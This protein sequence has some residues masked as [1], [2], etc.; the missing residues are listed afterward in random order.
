MDPL[1]VIASIAGVSTAGISLA[2][3]IYDAI[4]SMRDAPKEASSI[5]RGLSDLSSTLRELRR[6]LNDGR[7]IYRRRL[8]RRVASAV[9]R[10]SQIQHEIENLLVLDGPGS[11]GRLKWIFRKS[12]TMALLYAIESHKTGI[13]LVLHTMMLAVQLKQ[14]SN[15]NKAPRM[16]NVKDD[17]NDDSKDVTLARQQAETTVQ[18]SFHLLQEFAA[19]NVPPD[20]QNSHHM[21]NDGE[22]G[23]NTSSRQLQVWPKAAHDDAT[24]LYDLVFSAAVDAE[25]DSTE[26]I[27]GKTSESDDEVGVTEQ[28]SSLVSTQGSSTSQAVISRLGFPLGFPRDFPR[29]FPLKQLQ[30]LANGPPASS[31]VVNELLSEWTNLT[32]DEIA[33]TVRVAEE[34]K[35]PNHG[36]GSADSTNEDVQMISFKCAVGRRYILPSHMTL[37]WADMQK[38]IKNMYKQVDIL[39]PH[40]F[41][42]NYDL[43]D[44]KGNII[45]PEVWEYAIKGTKAISMHMWPIDR[46]GPTQPPPLPKGQSPKISGDAPNALGSGKAGVKPPNARKKGMA[47][48]EYIAGAI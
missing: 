34:S 30:V 11:L 41:A 31:A 22:H 18:A 46:G 24:W 25:R 32:E 47:A 33:G 42:G 7:D 8:I 16:T 28:R 10:I 21:N 13:S 6:V 38:L 15:K 37:T 12:K 35:K 3:A 9:R 23:D 5:A 44:S 1:S 40:V 29:D 27:A 39:E 17:N 19:D 20:V 48:M 14:L 26:T 43:V 36:P 2:R 45:L 4:L